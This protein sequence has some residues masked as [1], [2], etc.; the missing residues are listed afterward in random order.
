MANK[1]IFQTGVY[2]DEKAIIL[3]S[4]AIGKYK[5]VVYNCDNEPTIIRTYEN[6]SEASVKRL[7][8]T[9]SQTLRVIAGGG[10]ET[11]YRNFN[12]I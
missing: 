6:V 8:Y 4:L 1:L 5:A 3:T 10:I 7:E 2:K 11:S 9:G 12:R